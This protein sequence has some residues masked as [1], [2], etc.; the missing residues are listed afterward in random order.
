M[1]KDAYRGKIIRAVLGVKPAILA[2]VHDMTALDAICEHLAN[3]EKAHD[4]LRQKGYGSA[5]SLIHEVAAM[6]PEKA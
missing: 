1:S 3:C 6:V 2:R 4:L 5:G